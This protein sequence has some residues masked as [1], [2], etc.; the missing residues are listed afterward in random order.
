MSGSLNFNP[1]HDLIVLDWAEVYTSTR[2]R[3]NLI[4]PS[5]EVDAWQVDDILD[6][7][8]V[9]VHAHVGPRSRAAVFVIDDT[10]GI[11]ILYV[12]NGISSCDEQ[13]GRGAWRG[14]G[15]LTVVAVASSKKN[16]KQ[17]NYTSPKKI[18][19]KKRNFE[20]TT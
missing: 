13:N 6:L 18:K 5:L 15:E 8:A 20:G 1:V 10:I 12:S 4:L 7:A 3:I 2:S 17:Q 19:K 11:D 14:G 16:R 9:D